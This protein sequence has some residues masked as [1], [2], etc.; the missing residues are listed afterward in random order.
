MLISQNRD[1]N[2]TSPTENKNFT[3]DDD[4]VIE[5]ETSLEGMFK[6][7]YSIKSGEWITIMKEIEIS[8]GVFSIPINDVFGVPSINEDGV[9]K[10]R[11]SKSVNSAKVTIKIPE[12]ASHGTVTFF[13]IKNKNLKDRIDLKI[14]QRNRYKIDER[15][16]LNAGEHSF[17]SEISSYGSSEGKF[18]IQSG[19]NIAKEIRIENS[20][21]NIIVNSNIPDVEITI[22]KKGINDSTDYLPGLK[23]KIISLK[24][25][26]Y[27]L[28]F[29]KD[30]YRTQEHLITINPNKVINYDLKLIPQ[31]GSLTVN[32]YPQG[33]NFTIEDLV[34]FNKT[35]P[36]TID[37]V[38]T[39]SYKVNFS[40][41]DHEEFYDDVF[42]KDNIENKIV[43]TLKKHTGLLLL[44]KKNKKQKFTLKIDGVDIV[45]QNNKR[46]LNGGDYK[47]PVGTHNI[48]I[49]EE[50]F[51]QIKKTIKIL[52]FPK[53]KAEV[54]FLNMTPLLVDVRINPYSL[55]Y[56]M[57]LFSSENKAFN[58]VSIINKNLKLPYGKYEIKSHLPKYESSKISL[59]VNS[60]DRTIL[61]I[62]L[63]KKTVNKA[64]KY[65]LFPGA[66]LVY[67]EKKRTGITFFGSTILSS[68]FTYYTMDQYK[69]NKSELALLQNN[70]I[71]AVDLENMGNAKKNR[72]SKQV[73][74]SNLYNLRKQSI[75]ATIGIYV[76]SVG[77]TWMFNGL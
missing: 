2:I 28:E 29:T 18:V 53:N 74:V 63:N 14:N 45:E 20:Y 72:D 3:S 43:G 11:L 55:G 48:E 19:K 7:E 23:E 13:T 1:I 8:D 59:L 44:R 9:A 65:S 76:I 25:G 71:Q 4:L 41:A 57:T 62:K 24:K 47:I 58:N 50:G 15:I 12:Y 30:G 5:W 42:I 34:I 60:P 27:K 52:Q 39:R 38:A 37:S 51:N 61:P 69:K 33:A 36:Y 73:E 49:S 56:S 26:D 70:Y 31:H 46:S 64:L 17:E 67:A 54:I 40:L 10:L 68:L 32:S 75:G 77:V 21:G 16:S 22:A 6:L 35:T 66:G